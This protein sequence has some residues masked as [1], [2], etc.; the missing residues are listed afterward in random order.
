M[1]ERLT[2]EELE[3]L[4]RRVF[5]PG[6][7]DRH[8]AL[9]IDQPDEKRP[10]RPAWTDRRR[11]A[12]EWRDGL[13]ETGL[14]LESVELFAYPNVHANNADLPS[15]AV[16][17]DGGD[18]MD[19]D[20]IFSRYSILIALT[21]LSASA[22]LKIAAPRFGF[23][24]A[25]MPGFSREMIPAL[26]LD[27]DDVQRRCESIKAL[28]DRST[29]A[30]LTWNAG[31]RHGRFHID[32]RGRLAVAS[33]GVIRE[34]GIAG[35]LPSGETFIVPYEGE[36]PEMS[37]RTAGPLPLQLDGE[38]FFLNIEG[39]RVVS[40][41]GEGPVATDRRAA[42]EREPAYANVAELG[43]GILAD[44]GVSPVGETLLDEKLGLHI[45]FGRSDHFGGQVGAA[46]FSSPDKVIH[47]DRV[48]LPEVQPSV[49]VLAVDLVQQLFLPA[50]LVFDLV[51][52]HV[53]ARGLLGDLLFEGGFAGLLGADRAV[54]APAA[55]AASASA[56]AAQRRVARQRAVDQKGPGA[57]RGSD[58][59]RLGAD[60]CAEKQALDRAL[61][62]ASD[63]D[64]RFGRRI[65]VGRGLAARARTDPTTPLG[66]AGRAAEQHER[67]H[68]ERGDAELCRSTAHR[69]SY[70]ADRVRT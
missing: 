19:F 12:L 4:I 61:G 22:P 1:N 39:N 56:A 13:R 65:R 44:Y 57:D 34:P 43:L 54:T 11:L 52:E 14:D 50:E 9:L 3:A 2:V 47:I 26:R 36:Q 29:G 35:N 63:G 25:S 64:H 10:D 8:L 32:L 49:R 18:A 24:A 37:S 48:Y 28:L 67:T 15:T 58:R 62:S 66:V 30:T 33:G 41:E 27:F 17:T 53:A 23:R 16:S 59:P 20:K 68:E 7:D 21:E 45:A 60:D 46:D 31:G 40:V 70:S 51:L 6:P 42:F 5:A 55:V 69:C 38:L